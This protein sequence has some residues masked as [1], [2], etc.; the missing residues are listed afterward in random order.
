MH[1]EAVVLPAADLDEAAHRGRRPFDVAQP[2]PAAHL[3]PLTSGQ[4][5]KTLG[6]AAERLPGNPQRGGSAPLVEMHLAEETTEVGVAGGALHEEDRVAS[7][8][9][10]G[11]AAAIGGKGGALGL[12]GVGHTRRRGDGHLGAEYRPHPGAVA[13]PQEPDHPRQ[14]EVVGERHRR[15]T[16]SAGRAR[17][18]LG[19]D[20]A[21]TEREGRVHMEMD[22][23]H[24]EHE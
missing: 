14:T 16:Q 13:G 17:Q 21:V 12:G 23:R 2:E 6:V 19:P 15:H 5:E 20:G 18:S 24:G 7:P 3:A 22:E 1:L 11:R 9:Q 8:P 4:H 10:L